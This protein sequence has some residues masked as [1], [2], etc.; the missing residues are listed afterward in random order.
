MT[1]ALNTQS[2]SAAGSEI[3]FETRNLIVFDADC[4]ICSGFA[5][6]MARH[7]RRAQYKF[8]NAHSPIGRDLYLRFG[9]DADRMETNIVIYNEQA[10]T[11]MASFTTAM[12][13]LGW[14]WKAF[15]VLD[16]LPRQFADWL[17]DRI[18]QNRYRFGRRSCP[19]PTDNLRG[20]LLD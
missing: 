9:L 11:R 18:A 12:K 8:V 16:L 19:L 6:F 4:I 17:Y 3:S 15:A 14:P 1:K 7:D 10:F 20:R 2:A 5:R 13:S